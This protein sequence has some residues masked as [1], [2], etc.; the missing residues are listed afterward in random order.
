MQE[1]LLLTVTDKPQ[2]ADHYSGLFASV[3]KIYTK[4]KCNL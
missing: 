4:T 2:S 3:I 1:Y